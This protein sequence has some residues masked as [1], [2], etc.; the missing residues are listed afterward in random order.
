MKPTDRSATSSLGL[1]PLLITH[2]KLH[3]LLVGAGRLQRAVTSLPTAV[4]VV[5]SVCRNSS[6]DCVIQ[7]WLSL[8]FAWPDLE[9]SSLSCCLWTNVEF[10]S[11]SKA[12]EWTL[13]LLRL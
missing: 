1:A 5:F 3:G 13:R 9:Q 10:T 2:V 6:Q 4:L 11:G 8:V 12:I 7:A